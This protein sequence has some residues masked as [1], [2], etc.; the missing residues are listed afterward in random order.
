LDIKFLSRRSSDTQLITFDVGETSAPQKLLFLNL[1]K[2]KKRDHSSN[3][4]EV[5][6]LT[7][8]LEHL[9]LTW[10]EVILLLH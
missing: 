8:A 9:L 4:N 5:D 7:G 6:I 1:L 10:N 2:E 3:N